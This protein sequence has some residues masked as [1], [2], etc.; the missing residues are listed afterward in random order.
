MST[1]KNIAA[2]THNTASFSFLMKVNLF[3][4]LFS[5][6]RNHHWYKQESHLG[7]LIASDW[8]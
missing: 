6:T 3:K 8:M 7:V 5:V 1:N 4:V 2:A